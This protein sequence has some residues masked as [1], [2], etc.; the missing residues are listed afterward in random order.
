MSAES[1][2]FTPSIFNFFRAFQRFSGLWRPIFSEILQAVKLCIF[3]VKRDQPHNFQR[4]SEIFGDFYNAKNEKQ[5]LLFC[6]LWLGLGLDVQAS[7]RRRTHFYEDRS[8]WSLRRERKWRSEEGLWTGSEADS[9][10]NS[11][12]GSTGK[13]QG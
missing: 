13:P 10:L 5:T 9:E 1:H 8:R 2:N 7:A 12:D 3:I 11:L 6:F 4:F